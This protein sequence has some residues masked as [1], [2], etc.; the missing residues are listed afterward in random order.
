MKK[1]SFLMMAV[2]FFVSACGGMMSQP[3]NPVASM[4]YGDEKK[5]CRFIQQEVETVETDIRVKVRKKTNKVTTNVVLGAAGL[6]LFWPALFF[7]DF[8][9]KE[10]IEINALEKRRAGLL[11]V[12]IDKNC[13]FAL[14]A[15][16][17]KPYITSVIPPPK[18]PS[19][20]SEE[21]DLGSD[22]Q[23]F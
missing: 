8:S 9:G 6:L 15:D 17:S 7:M 23:D 4:Q 21:E 14:G 11:R 22:V 5:S 13:A 19:K 3:A 12:G 20:E 16:M 1:I 18:E 10:Q 2:V